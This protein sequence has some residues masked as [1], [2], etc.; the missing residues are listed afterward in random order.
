MADS[1]I[2]KKALASAFK[3][4][5]EEVPFE[6]INIASI[7]EKCGMNRKSFYYHFKDKYDLIN[8][9]F[10]TE[11]IDLM[12]NRPDDRWVSLEMMCEYFYA[13]RDFYCKA[14]RI[15]GQNSFS[16]HLREFARPLFRDRIESI[17][18]SKAI[19]QLYVDLFTDGLV[20]SMERWLL[21]KDRIPPEEFVSVM[22]LV[23][24]GAATEICQSIN[25]EQRAERQTE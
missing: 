10:D 5:M 11:I 12:V 18:N 6:K 21:D 15:A 3:G 16:E 22:K 8:W 25:E 24:Q 4:L 7:C 23:I 19:P 14:L 1:N 2:T 20:C 9:I 17:L 13:N